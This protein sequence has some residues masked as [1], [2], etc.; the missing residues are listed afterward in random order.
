MAAAPVPTPSKSSSDCQLPSRYTHCPPGILL[1]PRT[2]SLSGVPLAVQSNRAT[3]WL[4]MVH[5]HNLG[6][7]STTKLRLHLRPA[8]LSASVHSEMVR[9]GIIP[10]FLPHTASPTAGPTGTDAPT[11]SPS[12]TPTFSPSLAPSI[13]PS[14][15]P[16]VPSKSPTVV[17]SATPTEG[18]GQCKQCLAEQLPCRTQDGSCASFAGYGCPMRSC[19][20]L[21]SIF[22]V[23]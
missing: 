17:P 3:S 1:H 9:L 21:I 20:C 19:S 22:C 18:S 16:S 12:A 11:A 6:G 23:P 8:P 10:P 14:A 2:G 4:L 7:H 13:S 15:A 5:A